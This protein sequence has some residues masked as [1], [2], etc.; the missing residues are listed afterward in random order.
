MPEVVLLLCL[1]ERLMYFITNV[2]MLTQCQV[3]TQ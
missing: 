1:F 2:L 3:S